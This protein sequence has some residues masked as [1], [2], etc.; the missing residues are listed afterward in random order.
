MRGG[1]GK[2]P[3]AGKRLRQPA[4]QGVHGVQNGAQ[5]LGRILDGD[6]RG[7]VHLLAAQLPAQGLEGGQPSANAYP[8]RGQAAQ[9]GDQKRHARGAQHFFAQDMPLV[10]AIG[11]RDLISAGAQHIDPPWAALHFLRAQALGQTGKGRVRV[12]AGN[13]PGQDFALQRADF[14]GNAL[15][16][17][18]ADGFAE[19]SAD[20]IGAQR[21]ALQQAG[22]HA[23][24]HGQPSIQRTVQMGLH[25]AHHPAGGG[26]PEH[27]QGNAGD[28]HDPKTQ[29]HGSSLQPSR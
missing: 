19:V 4:Q 10:H 24:R 28:Q 8:Q 25:A 7:V 26:R 29:A 22:D 11:R 27:H 16:A 18:H 14:A 6:G 13:G 12:S 21:R 15:V 1:I 20:R 9:D 2:R 17:A 5:L 3:L 23:R